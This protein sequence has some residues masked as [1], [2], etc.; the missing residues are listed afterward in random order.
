SLLLLAFPDDT[1]TR[2]VH[3]AEAGTMRAPPRDVVSKRDVVERS[4]LG[5]PFVRD[6]V[7]GERVES[8]RET[9][10]EGPRGL[11]VDSPDY[12]I[13]KIDVDERASD[14]KSWV[15]AKSGALVENR[16]A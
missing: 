1:K 12:P 2:L 16:D 10:K 13:V 11:R 7:K 15:L 9:R 8:A 14:R 5:L 3:V 6:G 4:R